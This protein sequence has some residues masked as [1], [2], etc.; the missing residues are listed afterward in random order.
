MSKHASALTLSLQPG[1]KR[2]VFS[3]NKREKACFEILVFT[4]HDYH[5]ICSKTA[6]KQTF[7]LTVEFA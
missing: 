3:K 7:S 2:P 1:A 4:S 5:G 6:K